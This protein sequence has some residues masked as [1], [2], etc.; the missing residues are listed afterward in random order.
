MS[1]LNFRCIVD[2]F[3][4]DIT[5]FKPYAIKCNDDVGL[6][7]ISFKESETEQIRNLF[8]ENV[9][10]EYSSALDN[11]QLE[12]SDGYFYVLSRE[13]IDKKQKI[14][15]SLIKFRRYY[16]YLKYKKKER[17]AKLWIQKNL[18]KYDNGLNR[19][20]KG[21][22]SAY[23]YIDKENNTAFLR[24][25]LVPKKIWDPMSVKYREEQT[26]ITK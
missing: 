4:C 20:S 9:R 11:I 12:G 1:Q 18:E 24:A 13:R 10:E 16:W 3:L 17:K 15:Y 19:F 14:S 22:F 2:E 6:I 7:L 5:P 26:R 23:K 8:I 21:K 25:V